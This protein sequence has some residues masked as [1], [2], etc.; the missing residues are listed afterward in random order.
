MNPIFLFFFIYKYI[1]KIHPLWFLCIIVRLIISQYI[2]I[3]PKNIALIGLSIIGTGFTYKFITGS[4]NEIQIAKVFW[5]DSRLVHGILY[6]L[7][8]YYLFNNS[9]L[10]NKILL[11]DII[12]SFIY[13]FI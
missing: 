13:R 10:T 11:T 9:K 12:F 1:M 8:A 3:L 5:H 6:L 7:S 4:N 2:D